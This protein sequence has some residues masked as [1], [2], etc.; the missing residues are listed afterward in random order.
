[1]DQCF[2]TIC[3]DQEKRWNVF[4]EDLIHMEARSLWHRIMFFSS[5]FQWMGMWWTNSQLNIA[6]WIVFPSLS[7]EQCWRD[8]LFITLSNP[9]SKS[10]IG[11][12]ITFFSFAIFSWSKWQKGNYFL[13]PAMV[14]DW[15]L[16]TS[17]VKRE[18]TFEDP[19]F[20]PGSSFFKYS[21]VWHWQT[22]KKMIRNES[23][24]KEGSNNRLLSRVLWAIVT[25]PVKY[26]AA[27]GNNCWMAAESSSS[28]F[29][30]SCPF[31]WCVTKRSSN[32]GKERKHESIYQPTLIR[33]RLDRCVG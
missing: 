26:S 30:F 12:G 14:L 24:T 15:I 11:S 7:S 21:L 8:R 22:K 32:H 19:I 18:K 6:L 29:F 10:S 25:P 17:M 9:R 16:L 5:C 33:R 2:Y 3:K 23:Q 1:M 20:I 13:S 28:S 27:R 4:A 31:P